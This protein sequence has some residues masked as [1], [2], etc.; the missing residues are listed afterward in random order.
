MSTNIQQKHSRTNSSGGIFGRSKDKENDVAYKSLPRL[1]KDDEDYSDF[2]LE[3]LLGDSMASEEEIK[4]VFEQPLSHTQQKTVCMKI[5][6]KLAQR[7]NLTQQ[8]LELFYDLKF[9]QIQSYDSG[10]IEHEQLLYEFGKVIIGESEMEFM[11]EN[12]LKGSAWRNFGFQSDNPRTD[13][14]GSGL[15]GLK[16]LKYFAERYELSM[17]RMI[18]DQMYFWALTSIQ[19]THFLI[20]FFHMLKD[21]KTC[22]PNLLK[23]RAKRNQLKNFLSIYLQNP[24]TLA[25]IHS[26]A[27]LFN[28]HYWLKNQK[29]LLKVQ[30]Q[31]AKQAQ[32]MMMMGTFSHEPMEQTFKFIQKLMGFKFNGIIEIQSYGEILSQ[33]T[34]KKKFK[35]LQE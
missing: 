12:D 15:F 6:P 34:L 10:N 35:K 18:K 31:D 28:H 25:E 33:H 17:K 16:N 4:A 21:E 26:Q 9:F 14:R 2:K 3:D 29:V 19:I 5:F 23:Y 32:K 11:R 27:L 13:F 30:R 24:N 20:V 7:T 1:E 8:E 22:L